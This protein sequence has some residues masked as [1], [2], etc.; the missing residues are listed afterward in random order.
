[1]NALNFCRFSLLDLGVN[2]NATLAGVRD[3]Q[4]ANP[5]VRRALIAVPNLVQ[6]ELVSRVPF[7][8]SVFGKFGAPADTT[9]N[10]QVKA[11]I[12]A[13][14][15]FERLHAAIGTPEFT[16]ERGTKEST[17]E[18]FRSLVSESMLCMHSNL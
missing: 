8:Q 11:D 1:M 9:D 13:V 16:S 10:S 14:P 15:G 3:P 18:R 12:W 17:G 6:S 2:L 7:T 5:Q 4:T